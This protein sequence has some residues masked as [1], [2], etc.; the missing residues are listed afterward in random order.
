MEQR[1]RSM[2]YSSGRENANWPSPEELDKIIQTC[3]WFKIDD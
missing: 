2:R 3:G 1:R